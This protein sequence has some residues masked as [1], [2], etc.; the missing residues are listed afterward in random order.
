MNESS[1]LRLMHQVERLSACISAALLTDTANQTLSDFTTLQGLPDP[2]CLL[3]RD[4]GPYLA[5]GV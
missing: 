5:T 3:I 2:M 1:S 4:R